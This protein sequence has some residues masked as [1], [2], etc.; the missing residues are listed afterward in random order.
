MADGPKYPWRI[1]TNDRYR[2]LVSVILGLSTGALLL[3]V[4]L[5]RE[6][7]GVSEKTPLK[8]ALSCSAY[9]AWVF[10]AVSILNCI[11]FHFFSAKW[12]RLA[13]EQ[14]V[15]LICVPVSE[16]FVE[17]SLEISLWLAIIAFLAGIILTL[18]FLVGYVPRP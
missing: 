8:D 2:E 9:W 14:P 10:L 11:I 1:D 17:R 7:L 15:S 6:F 18:L 5:A 16:N 13:W 3:P 4:F 12:V